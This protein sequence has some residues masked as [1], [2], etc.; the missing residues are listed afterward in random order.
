MPTLTAFGRV[1]RQLRQANA[2]EGY[3]EFLAD[4]RSLDGRE[5]GAI[6]AE[7]WG[8][9]RFGQ[10]HNTPFAFEILQIETGSYD[11]AP[12][13]LTFTPDSAVRAMTGIANGPKPAELTEDYRP[14]LA[15]KVICG[16]VGKLP[17]EA[18]AEVER[19]LPLIQSTSAE[20]ALIA[21]RAVG[22]LEAVEAALNEIAARNDGSIA[23]AEYEIA[24][25]LDSLPKMLSALAE[26]SPKCAQLFPAF[27]PVLADVPEWRSYAERAVAITLARARDIADGRTKYQSDKLMTVAEAATVARAMRHAFEGREPWGMGCL[28]ELWLG[29]A[30]APDPKAKTAPSQSLAIQLGH[31]VIAQP[32]PEAVQ[33]LH[34]VAKLVRHAGVQ[35]KLERAAKSASSSLAQYPERVLD[36]LTHGDVAPDFQ[37][38]LKPALEGLLSRLW[39][40]D[41][42][43]WE[44][45]MT[46]KAIWA[47]T[48]S[49]IWEIA[50]HDG[51]FSAQPQRSG[52]T[53]AWHLSNGDMRVFDSRQKIR[54]WHPAE[55]CAAIRTAWQH[56][57]ATAEV[58]QPFAQA[59]RE[60]YQVSDADAAT[61]S[62]DLLAGYRVAQIPLFGLARRTGWRGAGGDGLILQF[63]GRTFDF[64]AGVR[65]WP[66]AGGEGTTG[67][68]RVVGPDTCLKEVPERI[69]SEA[70]RMADLLIATGNAGL[71]D[72]LDGENTGLPER[73][74]LMMRK[75]LL[76]LTR[77]TA[78]FDGRW[79]LLGTQ[80]RIHL[81]T[82]RLL[83]NGARID[84]E[85]PPK[86]PATPRGVD[87]VMDAIYAA[88]RRY[89]LAS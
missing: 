2:T 72:I 82:G 68:F 7:M 53:I 27:A 51:T 26:L 75:L 10:V 3:G 89:D 86:S 79:L 22:N 59:F 5:R 29:S 21:A 73:Q 33:T 34:K 52:K 46:D 43:A 54:L 66:G 78:R 65:T 58:I 47:F 20:M 50:D 83:L 80:H 61:R 63:A 12:I 19:L 18:I 62:T 81:G 9:G 16:T 37:K 45:Q 70:L 8:G 14:R 15:I 35:K 76:Q 17:P 74:S 67:A 30:L 24:A 4:I 13:R 31:A 40:L 41:A 49:L 55:A 6:L 1:L 39:W 77:P 42:P 84:P 32:Q 64:S 69:L 48:Q 87:P 88:I 25:R 57:I 85:I 71:K 11:E 38:V 28:E 36:L 44:R 23:F 56:H 60:I